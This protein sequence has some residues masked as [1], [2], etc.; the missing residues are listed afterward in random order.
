MW[1]SAAV[2][3][4][5]DS[6][7][8]R[9]RFSHVTTEPPA[10]QGFMSA[11]RGQLTTR[12]AARLSRVRVEPRGRHHERVVVGHRERKR[13]RRAG[14]PARGAHARVPVSVVGIPGAAA[15]AGTHAVDRAVVSA[16][17]GRRL[18]RNGAACSR[19]IFCSRVSE[20]QASNLDGRMKTRPSEGYEPFAG[21]FAC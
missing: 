9:D 19:R 8:R 5:S 4:K 16:G 2:A 14:P 10:A 11:K 20:H 18:G 7:P 12:P 1:R 3:F 6:L 15:A 17:R 21:R 13:A